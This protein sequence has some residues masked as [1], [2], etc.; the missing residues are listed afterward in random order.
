MAVSFCDSFQI[1][2][3]ALNDDISDDE[4]D[5]NFIIEKRTKEA[6]VRISP[7]AILDR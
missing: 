7:N 1:R 2:I 4:D 5:D 6:Q 3:A